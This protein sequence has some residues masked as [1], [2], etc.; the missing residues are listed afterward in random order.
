[1]SGG[2]TTDSSDQSILHTAPLADK[3]KTSFDHRSR[4]SDSATITDFSQE[5]QTSVGW[6]AG[7]QA[8][9]FADCT[10]TST[11]LPTARLI[12][13][14]AKLFPAVRLRMG[15]ISCTTRLCGSTYISRLA[16]FRLYCCR[17]RGCLLTCIYRVGNPSNPLPFPRSLPIDEASQMPMEGYRM[18]HNLT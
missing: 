14:P 18:S 17:V 7:S 15:Q 5:V 8:E 11:S 6:D 2:D 10:W 16:C 1:M 13:S 9:P 4:A 3:A 12:C